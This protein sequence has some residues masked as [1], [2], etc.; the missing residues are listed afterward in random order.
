MAT[1][2]ETELNLEELRKGDRVRLELPETM[3]ASGQKIPA[4]VFRG[5]VIRA[6]RR[7]ILLESL[8]GELLE[9]VA[10]KEMTIQPLQDLSSGGLP[11]VPR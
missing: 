4:Q 7:L 6:R 2:C 10:V 9:I 1:H 5:R 3:D 8:Y 11:P